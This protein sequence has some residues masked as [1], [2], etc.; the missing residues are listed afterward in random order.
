MSDATLLRERVTSDV[1][2][3]ILQL[4]RRMRHQNDALTIGGQ[5]FTHDAEAK[6]LN[7]GGRG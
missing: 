3:I 6:W 7:C 1:S 2:D 4:G 5:H